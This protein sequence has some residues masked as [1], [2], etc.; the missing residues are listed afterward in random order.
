[1]I[2]GKGKKDLQ[3]QNI[4]TTSLDHNTM[5]RL[6]QTISILA[7]GAAAVVRMM[8]VVSAAEIHNSQQMT[9]N[10]IQDTEKIKKITEAQEK[11]NKNQ[12]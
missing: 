3:I 5:C 9:N 4:L 8:S 6:Q 1:M 7:H 12:N 2:Q 11:F 10:D